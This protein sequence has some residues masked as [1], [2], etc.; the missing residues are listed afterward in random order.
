MLEVEKFPCENGNHARVREREIYE[1]LHATMNSVRPFRTIKEKKEYSIVNV[2]KIKVHRKKYNIDNAEKIKEQ[3]KDY[4]VKNTNKI[5]ESRENNKHKH[6]DKQRE[7]RAKN[8]DKIKEYNR[9]Y[10]LKKKALKA[11]PKVSDDEY[12]SDS[13]LWGTSEDEW[14]DVPEGAL[15]SPE[16]RALFDASR[17]RRSELASVGDSQGSCSEAEATSDKSFSLS[18]DV[19]DVVGPVGV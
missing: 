10:N 5:K 9:E 7:Y 11:A 3:L 4:R 13:S 16:M 8:A 12:D 2:E 18:A 6:L 15:I 14:F 19:I 17:E 1:E